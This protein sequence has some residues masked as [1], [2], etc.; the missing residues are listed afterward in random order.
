MLF[1]TKMSVKRRKFY[2]TIKLTDE[3]HKT[4]KDYLKTQRLPYKRRIRLS[5]KVGAN[6]IIALALSVILLV[7]LLLFFNK[8]I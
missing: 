2:Y 3:E 8:F 4:L 7:L 1:K 5:L 6:T